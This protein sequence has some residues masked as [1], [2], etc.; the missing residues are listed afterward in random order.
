MIQY[1]QNDQHGIQAVQVDNRNYSL[2]RYGVNL[3]LGSS[4]HILWRSLQASAPYQPP[5]SPL[6]FSVLAL[7]PFFFILLIYIL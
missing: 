1:W 5:F 3:C 6:G 2:V 7:P 4:V